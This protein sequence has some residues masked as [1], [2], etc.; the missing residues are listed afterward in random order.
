[1]DVGRAESLQKKPQS[2]YFQL[3]WDKIISTH[4]LSH[5]LIHR[6]PAEKQ[7][8]EES[9]HQSPSDQDFGDASV[10]GR[11]PQHRRIQKTGGCHEGLWEGQTALWEYE[12][13]EC[14][15]PGFWGEELGWGKSQGR[16]LR[17]GGH[18]RWVCTSGNWGEG[19]APGRRQQPEPGHRDDKLGVAMGNRQSA[20]HHAKPRSGGGHA[21][22]CSSPPWGWGPEGATR[23]CSVKISQSGRVLSSSTGKCQTP[24]PK[25]IPAAASTR[26]PVLRSC[27][28]TGC[29]LM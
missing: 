14:L 16:V 6:V 28:L 12:R 8:L 26:P 15:P 11:P 24:K 20:W 9:G 21:A 17:G 1:M 13:R 18:S 10:V 7:M 2:M 25:N 27:E 22:A 23:V 5:Q 3:N 4:S 19:R 29:G